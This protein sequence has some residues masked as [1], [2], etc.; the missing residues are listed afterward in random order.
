MFKSKT[1]PQPQKFRNKGVIELKSPRLF[2]FFQMSF[3]IANHFECLPDHLDSQSSAGQH[4]CLYAVEHLSGETMSHAKSRIDIQHANE[5][6]W[7][8]YSLSE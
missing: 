4:R 7:A 3:S 6:Y 1:F 5:K 2:L 8:S